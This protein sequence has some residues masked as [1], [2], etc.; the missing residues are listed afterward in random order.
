MIQSGFINLYTDDMPRALRFYAEALGFRET[1]RVPHGRPRPRRAGL[2]HHADRVVHQPGR[3]GSP[4]HRPHPRCPSGCLVLWVHDLD[5]A[6]E[7]A[8]RAGAVVVTAPHAAGNN[9]RNALL[10]DPDRNLVELV[11]K[12]TAVAPDAGEDLQV[13]P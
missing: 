13:A 7:A 2:R 5:A 9:N 4:R 8:T 3:S 6:F 1:F 11:A 10:R 12:A